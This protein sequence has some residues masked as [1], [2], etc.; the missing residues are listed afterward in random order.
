M[1]AGGKPSPCRTGQSLTATATTLELL[2][3]PSPRPH[4]QLWLPL[5]SSRSSHL[6]APWLWSLKQSGTESHWSQ[7]SMAP[8]W[9]VTWEEPG[10]L[11]PGALP[12][13]VPA[14]LVT[15]WGHFDQEPLLRVALD[16][17]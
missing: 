4:N 1:C 8:V 6:E 3:R 10:G 17:P 9:K 15:R 14:L 2:L 11:V 12:G 7:I 13:P 16:F 5:T